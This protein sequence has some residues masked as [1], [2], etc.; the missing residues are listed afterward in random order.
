MDG[1][2][3]LLKTTRPNEVAMHP[4]YSKSA[5][6]K[7]LKDTGAKDMRKSVEAMARRVD[8]HFTHD[9]D[10]N[11]GGVG[12]PGNPNNHTAFDPATQAL[13]AHVW[14]ELSSELARETTRAIDTIAKC[15]ENSL[16]LDYTLRDLESAYQRAKAT[17]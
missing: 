3:R 10:S 4:S 15:Y 11:P 2:E 7:V 8:K 9:D 6:K 1:V 5:L 13:I 16:T 12:G 14:R 17:R